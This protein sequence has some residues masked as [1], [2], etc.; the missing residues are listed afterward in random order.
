MVKK[1][2]LNVLFISQDTDLYKEVNGYEVPGDPLFRHEKYQKI[3]EEL[4]SSYSQITIIV[5]TKRN[6]KISNIRRR[7]SSIKIIPSNS[8][9]RWSFFTDVIYEL[10]KLLI[11]GWKPSLISTQS[12]WGEAF[13]GLFFSKILSCGFLPQIHTDISSIFWFRENILLNIFRGFQTFIIL[14]YSKNIRVVSKVSA[15]NIS[16]FYRAD[17][18]KMKVTPVGITLNPSIHDDIIK[19]KSIEFKKILTI[20]FIGRLEEQKDLKLW[21]D[22]AFLLL[23]K[24]HNIEF[25]IIGGGKKLNMVKSLIKNSPHK[26]KFHVL[27][28]L[29]YKKLFIHYLNADLFFLSSHHEGFGRVI[30]EAMRFGL[31]CVSTGSGG[32][33]DL[34]ENNINGFIVNNRSPKK[35]SDKIYSI[36]DDHNLFRK[37]SKASLRKAEV[38]FSFDNLSKKFVKLLIEASI[39]Y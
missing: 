34:I 5:Y 25:K 19:K 18:N 21:L 29:S 32:P 17:K 24:N 39:N 16:K 28:E 12:T 23:S 11:K 35:I 9:F 22:T 14:K 33:E 4:T 8:F 6:H 13:I 27:G 26:K 20:L 38:T 2:K 36:L 31:P 37:M 10:I 15:K 3:L 7:K 30:L 1:K